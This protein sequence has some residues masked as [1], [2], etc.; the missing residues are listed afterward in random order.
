[1]PEAAARNNL[2]IVGDAYRAFDAGDLDAVTALMDDGIEWIEPEG[3]AVGGTHRG[4][5]AVVEDVFGPTM[6][7]FDGFEVEVERFVDGGDTVVALGTSHGTHRETGTSI[8][9]P[10]AHVI[11]L[12]DGRITRFQQ[13]TNTYRW[14]RARGA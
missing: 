8:D 14:D 3:L 2:E 13:H 9:A 6:A 11:D 4:P 7:E 12:A 5:G 10:F 1:M